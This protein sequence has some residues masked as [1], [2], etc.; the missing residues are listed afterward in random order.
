VAR[1]EVRRFK[2]KLKPAFSAACSAPEVLKNDH[3]N[4]DQ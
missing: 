3:R 1:L 2:Q 4:Q